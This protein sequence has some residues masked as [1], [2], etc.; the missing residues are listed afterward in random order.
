MHK[1]LSSFNDKHHFN[2]SRQQWRIYNLIDWCF[3]NKIRV[4]IH[5][6]IAFDYFIWS[7]IDWI[8]MPISP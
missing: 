4:R 2:E 8:N 5:I 1:S 3:I 7:D 6:N